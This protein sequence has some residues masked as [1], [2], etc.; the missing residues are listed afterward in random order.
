MSHN[1]CLM[2]LIHQHYY[3]LPLPTFLD[4]KNKT[5]ARRWVLPVSLSEK[6]QTSSTTISF[7]VF[8]CETQSNPTISQAPA[9]ASINRAHVHALHLAFTHLA[10]AKFSS[11]SATA[12]HTS[13]RLSMRCVF[14]PPCHPYTPRFKELGRNGPALAS[15][16]ESQELNARLG[17]WSW[18]FGKDC[19]R[20]G[21]RCGFTA[22]GGAGSLWCRRRGIAWDGWGLQS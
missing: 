22:A 11:P 18:R 19:E 12:L 14:F 10:L 21:A 1:F 15:S 20:C 8:C 17:K 2:Q 3:T 5:S 16:F 6:Y 9:N 7:S 13:I 4:I